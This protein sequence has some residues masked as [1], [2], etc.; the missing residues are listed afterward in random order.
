[1]DHLLI[2]L[3]TFNFLFETLD[4]LRLRFSFN[5][6]TKFIQSHVNE[7]DRVRDLSSP[8][9][10]SKTP[11]PPFW[12]GWNPRFLDVDRSNIREEV[13]ERKGDKEKRWKEA[14]GYGWIFWAWQFRLIEGLTG[15]HASALERTSVPLHGPIGEQGPRGPFIGPLDPA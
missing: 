7:N 10:R 1:M 6:K 8:S 3:N 13:K 5:S 11:F 12:K 2:F 14:I 4:L 9:R 15:I